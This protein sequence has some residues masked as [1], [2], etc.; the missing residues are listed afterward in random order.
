MTILSA[1]ELDSNQ[2]SFQVSLEEFSGPFDLLLALISKHKL[3]VTELAL[4]QVTDDFLNY[5][6][7]KGATLPLEEISSFLVI[8]A[9]L[10]DLKTARLIPS[11]EVE[12]EE[13]IAL[14]EAADILFARILQYRAYKQ[15]S[16]V[17]KEMMELAPR[18]W[19]RTAGFDPGLNQ[20]LPEVTINITPAQFAAV[21]VTSLLPRQLADISISHL[22]SPLVSVKEQTQVIVMKLSRAKNLSFAELVSDC[23]TTGHIVASF[24]SILELFRQRLITFEQHVPLGPLFIQWQGSDDIEYEI[25]TEFDEVIKDE[26]EINGIG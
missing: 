8:A 22:H 4:S 7:E 6:K 25:D 16:G 21:A 23:E 1:V 13:D 12:D 26:D 3:E 2:G 10:L 9:T 19:P 20:L 17:I 24:L 15:V 5:I 11:G 14:L 18:R